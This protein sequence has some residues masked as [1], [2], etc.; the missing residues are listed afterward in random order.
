[1]NAAATEIRGIDLATWEIVNRFGLSV[2]VNPGELISELGREAE[3]NGAANPMRE[4]GFKM[5]EKRAA[6]RGTNRGIT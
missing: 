5:K 4:R 3:R 6:G 1:M 2:Q